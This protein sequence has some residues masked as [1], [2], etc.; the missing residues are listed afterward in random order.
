[1]HHNTILFLIFHGAITKAIQNSP[2]TSSGNN[3]NRKATQST[4]LLDQTN[5]TGSEPAQSAREFTHG[6][7]PAA[8]IHVTSACRKP[9]RTARLRTTPDLFLSGRKNMGH[10]KRQR[11]TCRG[12]EDRPGT[13]G[14]PG[15]AEIVGIRRNWGKRMGEGTGKRS[16]REGFL[17]C[18]AVAG[19]RE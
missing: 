8:P 15:S 5:R 11:R 13:R 14:N 7:I 19:K 6:V 18:A 17:P 2:I 3:H 10:E 1:M 16:E 9:K 4:E 12:I